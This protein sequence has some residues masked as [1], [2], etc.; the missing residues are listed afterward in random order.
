MFICFLS[1]TK[2]Q[3]STSKLCRYEE[4]YFQMEGL[5]IVDMLNLSCFRTRGV[6]GASGYTR[7]SATGLTTENETSYGVS[8]LEPT[9][10]SVPAVAP[11]APLPVPL[12]ASC[13]RLGDTKKNK[14]KN[15]AKVRGGVSRHFWRGAGVRQDRARRHRR[16]GQPGR[17]SPMTT[18]CEGGRCGC[19][20][21][22][23]VVI[24]WAR[25]SFTCNG[26]TIR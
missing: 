15:T 7:G 22:F 17:P 6:K 1:I 8:C 2:R 24:G 9:N 20:R 19:G 16:A 12:A 5:T 26:Y 23:F 18:V 11:A 3:Q 13:F 4:S 25:V 21:V 10:D 14:Q